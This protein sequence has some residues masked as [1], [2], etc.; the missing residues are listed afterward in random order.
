[1]ARLSVTGEAKPP[2]DVTVIVKTVDMP[3]EIVCFA[4]STV[5]ANEGAAFAGVTR[6]SEVTTSSITAKRNCLLKAK[7]STKSVF[8]S[9]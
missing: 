4:G 1:L 7:N 6:P 9:A 5:R 3:G 2:L 8:K